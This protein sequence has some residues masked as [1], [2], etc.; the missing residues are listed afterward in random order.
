MYSHIK[1]YSEKVIHK[2]IHIFHNAKKKR[3][4]FQ[5]VAPFFKGGR[6]EMNQ[7]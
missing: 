1:F 6:F 5:Q 7:N 3:Q 2:V 4:A